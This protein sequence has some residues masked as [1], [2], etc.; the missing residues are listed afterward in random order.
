MTK[1]VPARLLA[2]LD[3]NNSYFQIDDVY[4]TGILAEKARVRRVN[5]PGIYLLSELK[6]MDR[7]ECMRLLASFEY[8]SPNLLIEAWQKYQHG[9]KDCM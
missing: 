5:A 6:R 9:V 1:D 3:R 2:E 8:R 4:F 7:C